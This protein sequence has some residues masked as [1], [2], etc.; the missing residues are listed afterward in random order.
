M[1]EKDMRSRCELI[2]LISGC[3]SQTDFDGFE[4]VPKQ[5]IW[6]L[7]QNFIS[8]RERAANEYIYPRELSTNKLSQILFV[9]TN[10][11]LSN[12]VGERHHDS[13]IL[14]RIHLKANYEP[15]S[16]LTRSFFIWAT[17]RRLTFCL[18]SNFSKIKTD[19]AHSHSYGLNV[20]VIML[21]QIHLSIAIFEYLINKN[22]T[23]TEFI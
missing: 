7:D 14:P 19:I 17:F 12:S 13:L 3:I 11:N 20:H 9:R 6:D 2:K 8:G 10:S 21:V 16:W 18:I 5:K 4:F 23:M 1:E 22:L 15:H